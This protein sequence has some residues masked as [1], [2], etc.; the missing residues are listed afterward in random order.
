[1]KKFNERMGKRQKL[2][3]GGLIKKIAGR[4][5]F[6]AGGNTTL[7]GPSNTTSSAS[8]TGASNAGVGGVINKASSGLTQAGNAVSKIPG[9]GGVAGG[10]LNAWA[11]PIQAGLGFVGDILGGTQNQF[12]ATGANI[13][14]GTNAD[15]LNNAYTGAQNA[16]DQQQGFAGQMQPGTAQG[17]GT[18]NALTGQLQGVINGTGPNA[19]QAALAANTSKNVANQA[20]LMAGQRGSSA[21]AGLL[22][23]Q[24][25]QQGAATQQEAV[26]QAGLQQAQQQIAAQQQLQGLAG[27]Q[28]GQGATAIQGL[29]NAQQNE[30]NILQGANT[31]FNNASVANQAN[32]NNVNAGVAAGNQKANSGL[33]GGVLGGVGSALGF[34]QGGEVSHHCAGAHCTDRQHS[35]HM[36]ASGGQ[37][38]VA[39]PVVQAGGV[40]PWLASS[41][42]TNG[43]QIE[44]TPQ[45]P[46]D[47]G[48]N[49]FEYKKSDPENPSGL[50][51]MFHKSSN[52]SQSGV[53]SNGKDPSTYKN[54][55]GD[56]NSAGVS[57]QQ[58]DQNAASAPPAEEVNVSSGIG[59]D[60]PDVNMDE[61]GW[62]QSKPDTDAPQMPGSPAAP[63]SDSGGGIASLIPLAAMALNHGGEI[64]WEQHF[65]GGGPVKAMVSAGERYLNPEEVKKV[66]HEGANPLKSGIKFSGKA[67]VKG[68]SLKNDTI[69]ATLEEGGVV[70]PRHIMNKKNRDHAELFVRRAVHMKSPKGGK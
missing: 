61:G 9:I 64:D 20:A 57:G 31:A 10:A 25:A 18:Q 54:D 24:A 38:Q 7:S 66:I 22:A 42:N 12:Q 27:Q 69:P 39:P 11:S 2:S 49:P 5:Y 40:G 47:N 58:A 46:V 8:T 17:L 26:G 59:S 13:Q 32:V 37:L 45:Q 15:Q 62:L 3:K 19:A 21:N 55:V 43:P 29:N 50:Y 65:Y 52:T 30:Q 33:L 4:H 14:A 41:T 16:L 63:S 48:P 34:A 70:I 67:K 60:L 51:K 6:D 44:A 56:Y 36:M 68:D 35:M 53:D 23:R 28:V 1:M